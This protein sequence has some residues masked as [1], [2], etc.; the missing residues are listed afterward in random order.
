MLDRVEAESSE[1]RR[2]LVGLRGILEVPKSEVDEKLKCDKQ[3][4][5]NRGS[6]KKTKE[7]DPFK[8]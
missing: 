2:F 3:K 7:R 4:R 1:A 8:S 6:S 5:L